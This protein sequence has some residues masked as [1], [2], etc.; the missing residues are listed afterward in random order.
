MPACLTPYKP[1]CSLFLASSEEVLSILT[2]ELCAGLPNSH[3]LLTSFLNPCYFLQLEEVL[4]ILT[5][6]LKSRSL[7]SKFEGKSRQQGGE[8]LSS[9]A[10]LVCLLRC[11][12]PLLCSSKQIGS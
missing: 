4:S 11:C 6:E 8:S 2:D 9:V 5:D 10:W 1:T 7:T 12:R 3:L